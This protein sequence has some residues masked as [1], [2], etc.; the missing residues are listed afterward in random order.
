M[1]IGLFTDSYVPRIDGIAITT[2]SLKKNLEKLGHSVVI[3]C[4]KRPETDYANE[5]DVIALNSK[6]SRLYE[7]YQTI[8]PTL[9]ELRRIKS[10]DFD[11]IH[12]LSQTHVGLLAIREAKRRRCAL[13]NTV[14]ADYR[15]AGVYAK[16]VPLLI[17][18][19]LVLAALSRRSPLSSFI[20][21]LRTT[22]SN[23][24]ERLSFGFGIFYN[25]LCDSV[26][27]PSKRVE[28]DLKHFGETKYLDVVP[29]GFDFE[30]LDN[31]PD[32]KKL[33]RRYKLEPDDIV[34]LSSSRLVPE[35]RIEF[36]IEAYLRIHEK[37]RRL[38]LVIVGDGPERARLEK[39]AGGLRDKKIIFTGRLPRKDVVR[40]ATACD[41]F[42]H[43]SLLETQGM[44]LNEAAAA[45]LPII[46]L[47]RKVSE[48]V[49]DGKTGYFTNDVAEMAARLDELVGNSQLRK[50]MSV[51]AKNRAKILD[52]LAQTLKITDVYK[53][54][55]GGRRRA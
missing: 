17:L 3:V 55:I 7:G 5:P 53:R 43:A 20:S 18:T 52:A 23:L 32:R 54:S 22:G 25:S 9:S 14:W 49:I 34:M 4:P 33:R 28:S 50:K 46:M 31:C 16:L 26:I 48:M 47:D 6:P 40:L 36:V 38:K 11:V 15:L 39:L 13:V 51:D 42:A 30:L 19:T 21:A 10:S 44:V 12:S 35:K 29:A 45:G 27:V 37:H 1:K 8:R 2:E 24:P 41:I